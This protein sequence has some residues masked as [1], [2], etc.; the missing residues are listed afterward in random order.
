MD[1]LFFE[2]LRLS[3]DIRGSLSRQ[4]STDEWRCLYQTAVKQSLLGVCFAGVRK[5]M[6]TSKQNGEDVAIPPKAYQHWLG[7]AVHIQQRNEL[8][9][10]RCVEFEKKL[11]EDGYKSCVLKGQGL[12]ALYGNLRGLRQSGDIDTWAL[13][14]PKEIIEWAR[15]T[16]S[17]TFYDYHHADLSL[18]QDSEIELHYRPTLSRNLLR[19]ARLQRWFREDG[20]KHFVFNEEQGFSVPDY[21]FNVVLILNH[22]LWHLMYEGVGLRQILD[23]FFVLRSVEEAGE[24][25]EMLKTEVLALIKHFRLQRFAEASMWIMKETLGLE[26]KYLICQPNESAGRFLLEEIIQ[27]GNFGQYD[28]RLN[29][30]RYQSRI[31]LMFSWMKHNFRLL[32]YYPEDVLW[33]PIGVLRI[34][35]WRRFHYM[36]ETDLKG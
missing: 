18:Y 19:N 15:K 31:G 16:G 28:S 21:T 9:N 4:P 34:S 32:K 11:T 35:L 1:T 20:E 3:I 36:N 33:T 29:K 24:H 25:A 6:E 8:M 12:D 13:G 26:D 14:E 22:N 27:S 2:L 23:L 7:A 5:H 17:M 10:R 30:N